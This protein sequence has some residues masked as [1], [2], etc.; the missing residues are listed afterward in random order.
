MEPGTENGKVGLTMTIPEVAETFG[1][2]R[3]QAYE[4]ASQNELPVPV[5]RIGRQL[6]VS[7]ALVDDLLSRTHPQEDNR[8]TA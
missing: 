1:I 8:D 4:L 7:R 2:S 3:T 5:I 6:R